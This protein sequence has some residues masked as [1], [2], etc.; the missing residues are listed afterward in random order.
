MSCSDED[1]NGAQGSEPSGCEAPG[2]SLRPLPKSIAGIPVP[3]SKLAQA[4]AALVFS[5]SPELL[6]NHCMRT[7][8]FAGLLLGTMD[9]KFDQELA[10][11]GSALHDLGLLDAFMSPTERFEIDGADAA[12]KF[13]NDWCVPRERAEIV[14]DAIAL[15]TN[16]GIATRKA[17]EIAAVSLG[18]AMDAGGLGLEKLQPASV[19]EV[20]LTF[21]RLGFK[22]DAVQRMT[23][24]CEKKP[25]AQ[26]LHPFAEVGR[27][28][29]PNFALPTIEDL[30]LG[31]PFA[32]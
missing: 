24:L 21:P 28:H 16:M 32:E 25:F 13:M 31:A 6:Y 2:A 29:I 20:I 30:I 23:A 27:R 5:A 22:E 3:D 12:M 19:A 26:L 10:F 15:H 17:P 7:Y 4:A 14:W 8:V 9:T 18:A 11:V 1:A